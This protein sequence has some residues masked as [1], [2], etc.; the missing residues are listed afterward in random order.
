M[1]KDSLKNLTK[2]N[3]LAINHPLNSEI[4][5][6]LFGPGYG[7]CIVIHLGSGKWIIVDSCL[8]EESREPAALDYLKSIGINYK[9]DVQLIVA[10]HWHDDHIRGL[11]KII[12]ECTN[13]KLTLSMTQRKEEFL[14]LVGLYEQTKLIKKSGVNEFQS[15][16]RYLETNSKQPVWAI[17]GRTIFSDTIED[18]YAVKIEAKSPSD[19]SITNAINLFAKA[20]PQKYDSQ[21]IPSANPNHSSIV[22]SINIGNESILLGADLEETNDSATGWSIIV[23]SNSVS[24]KKAG[25]FKVPHHGSSNGDNPAVWKQMIV[26]APLAILTPFV[27][28]K[29]A[30]PTQSDVTRILSHTNQAYITR[31]PAPGKIPYR[32]KDGVQKTIL[33]TTRYIRRVPLNSG[34]IRLRKNLATND[35]WKIKLFGSAIQLERMETENENK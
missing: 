11:G 34:Q 33:E 22:L 32:K 17:E 24:N 18:N 16:L 20:F 29:K 19:K 27:R 14:Q 30:L 15:I 28:G 8:N 5:L 23:Q 13:A 25:V 1:E 6:S 35:T 7:E 9:N 3:N 4:E 2:A 21:K 26:P 12:N 10:T 31:R